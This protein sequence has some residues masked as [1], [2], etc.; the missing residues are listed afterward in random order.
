MPRVSNLTVRGTLRLAL[1]PL[2]PCVPGFGALLVSLAR[3]PQ[4]KFGLDFG[5]ALGGRYTARPVAAFLDPFL[6]DTLANALVW[7]QRCGAKGGG[8]ERSPRALCMHACCS[9]ACL[10]CCV[11]LHPAPLARPST[12][13]PPRPPPPPATRKTPRRSVVVPLLPREVTGPLDALALRSV[14]VLAVEVLEARGL[15]RGGGWLSTLDP[16][17]WL[18]LFVCVC[19]CL[20]VC[21]W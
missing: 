8:G 4:V 5:P 21:G 6:R 11:S 12:P 15:A 9:T 19:V 17:V 10:P 3:A 7:P 18:C 14:G 16:Q 1:A 13:P 20:C 2:A